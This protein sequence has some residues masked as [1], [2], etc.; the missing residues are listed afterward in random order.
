MDAALENVPPSVKTGGGT[1]EGATRAEEMRA[2]LSG[3]RTEYTEM[4]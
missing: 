1:A 4:R 3:K 2:N